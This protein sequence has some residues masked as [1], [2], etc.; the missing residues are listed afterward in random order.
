M[1]KALVAVVLMFA[2][3]AIA[4][5][6]SDVMGAPGPTPRAVPPVQPTATIAPPDGRLRVPAPIDRL[7]VR[8]LESAPPRYV[9]NVLAGLPSGCVQRDSHTV[10]RSGDIV[11]VTVLNSMPPGNPICT[12]IYGTYELNVDLGS[13]FTRGTT[14]TVRVNDKTTT[15]TAR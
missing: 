15:F 2:T 11:T 9:V 5:V 4:A 7:D 6:A 14:Y 13:A 8:V 1:K 3:G 12:M 10:D